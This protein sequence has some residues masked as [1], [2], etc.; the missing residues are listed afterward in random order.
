MDQSKLH[1]DRR[2]FLLA[3]GAGVSL[4]GCDEAESIDFRAK[5]NPQANQQLPGIP[6]QVKAALSSQSFRNDGQGCS[7][8]LSFPM[9]VGDQIRVT[10]ND[11][12]YALYTVAEKRSQD[13]PNT[14]RMGLDARLRLGTSR[15]FPA[16]VR[17]PVLAADPNMSDAEAEAKSEFVERLVDDPNNHGLC[18]IA[19]HGGIIETRTDRQA[20][21]VT[22]VLGCSSWI[23]KGWKQGG[24]GFE[25]WHITSTKLSR[26][27]FPGLDE[28][29]DRMFK[30]CVSF[31]GMSSGGVLIGGGASLE[32][33]EHVRAAIENELIDN[34]VHDVSVDL[35][36]PGDEFD[37]DSP[38]NVVNRLTL[39]GVGG[40][41]IE[42]GR[43][44]R[45]EHWELIA[46]GVINAYL[47][48]PEP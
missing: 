17:I 20:E 43:T 26:N 23:C 3:L 2:E 11:L 10:R 32:L 36:R 45:I 27:S 8:P 21:L 31:H 33:R 25:R 24:G 35:A 12:E 42:Q 41:Q 9:A 30:Y 38:N 40:V 29:H 22:E 44:V 13:D 1:F 15:D 46:Q 37:G 14:V 5:P 48:P 16:G 7:I 34:G 6:A 28:I 4:L 18:V 19:P 39:N 47:D